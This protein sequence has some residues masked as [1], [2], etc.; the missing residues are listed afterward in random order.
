MKIKDDSPSNEYGEAYFG[1][2]K[3]RVEYILGKSIINRVY[4][5]L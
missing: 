5:E 2:S 4:E 3:Q 1:L